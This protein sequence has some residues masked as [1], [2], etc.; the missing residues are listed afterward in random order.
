MKEHDIKLSLQETEQLCRLYLDCKL[1]VLEEVELQYVLGRLD[2]D[3]PVIAD[4]R[5]SMGISAGMRP[6]QTF[7]KK[8]GWFGH[9]GTAA[10]AASLTILF[11]V[12]I[13]MINDRH[14]A[15]DPYLSNGD[16]RVYISAYSN[17]ERLDGSKAVTATNMAIAKA[18]SLMKYASLTE[19]AYLMKADDIISVTQNN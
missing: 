15:P 4:A 10:I 19:R 8:S 13:T 6:K 12:G 16:L 3:S 17:G 1:S 7:G 9:R 5:L 11:A 2:Y 14:A 18:D